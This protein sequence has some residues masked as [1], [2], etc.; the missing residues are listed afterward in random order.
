MSQIILVYEMGN[1]DQV[2]DFFFKFYS[3]PC[4]LGFQDGLKWVWLGPKYIEDWIK[5]EVLNPI[6]ENWVSVVS[7]KSRVLSAKIYSNLVWKKILIITIGWIIFQIYSHL[8]F[9]SENT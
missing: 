1:V 6:F 3:S 9:L 8:T 7:N 5:G 2:D 4:L